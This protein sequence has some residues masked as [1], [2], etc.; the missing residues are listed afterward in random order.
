MLEIPKL[1]LDAMIEQARA[2]A[3]AEC[4]GVLAGRDGRVSKRFALRNALESPLRYSAE[5]RDLFEAFRA[6]RAAGLELVAIYHSHPAAPARP[7]QVDLEENY[8]GDVPRIIISLEADPPETKAF[9]LFED[10][11]EEVELQIQ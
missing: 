1:I 4:C 3:P 6:M 9:R 11:Y 5:V 8:Y 10:R 7:S 2:E